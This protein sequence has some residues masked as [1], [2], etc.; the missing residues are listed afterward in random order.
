MAAK[1][2]RHKKVTALPEETAL[3]GLFEELR[4]NKKT[5]KLKLIA[6]PEGEAKMSGL[7]AELIAPYLDDAKTLDAYK[8]LVATACIAWNTALLPEAEWSPA[9]NKLVSE[10][11]A[12]PD[13]FRQDMLSII[14][15]MIKR[16]LELF[17]DNHR[18][19]VN[20]K[21]TETKQ[22]YHLAIASTLS[23]RN[24]DH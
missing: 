22:N 7:I 2:N 3:P 19:V 8:N 9:I 10:L 14:M 21:V 18:Q 20:F 6:N 11:G 1:R 17:P 23:P 24:R 16:K 13:E 15:E 12:V 4:Q 5:E